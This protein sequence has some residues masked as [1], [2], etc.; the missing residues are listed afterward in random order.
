MNVSA[1][2]AQR[3]RLVSRI[4]I[5]CGFIGVIASA[6]ALEVLISYYSGHRPAAPQLERGWTVGISWTHPTRYGTA[7]EEG[8][9]LRLF[10][11]GLPFFCLIALGAGIR[12]YLLDDYSVLKSRKRA[13]WDHRW[14]PQ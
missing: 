13:P 3:W 14:G 4:L 2:A 6:I 8:N 11:L 5:A 7:Q 9:V 12:I 10:S 1:A